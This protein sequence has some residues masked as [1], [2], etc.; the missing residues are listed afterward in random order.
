VNKKGQL[1]SK[2]VE[3]YLGSIIVM[4]IVFSSFFFAGNLRTYA[5]ADVEAVNTGIE[6]YNNLN[7]IMKSDIIFDEKTTLRLAHTS[8]LESELISIKN[9]FQERNYLDFGL[10]IYESCSNYDTYQL[11]DKDICSDDEPIANI[12][13]ENNIIEQKCAL[14]FPRICGEEICANYLAMEVYE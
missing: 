5:I 7:N 12:V 10:K 9:Y 14:V 2:M 4:I 13:E 6:C 3:I 11:V 8:D 1:A